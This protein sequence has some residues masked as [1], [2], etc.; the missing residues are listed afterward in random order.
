[1]ILEKEEIS[2]RDESGK[3]EVLPGTP[4]LYR[5]EEA[6]PGAGHCS[7]G[8]P[9]GKS[10]DVPDPGSASLSDGNHQQRCEEARHLP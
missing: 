9:G 1:M 4:G 8:L 5:T 10:G 7:G 6:A 2:W 3:Y